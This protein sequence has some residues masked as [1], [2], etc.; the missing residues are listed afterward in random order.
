MKRDY[1]K[2]FYVKTFMLVSLLTGIVFFITNHMDF[3]IAAFEQTKFNLPNLCYAAIRLITCLILPA[4]FVAPSIFLYSRVRIAKVCFY[5]QS[6]LHL[7]TLTW[8][9]YFF[10][11]GYNLTDLFSNEAITFFQQ[12]IS[13]AFI[14][15]QIFWDTYDIIATLFTLILSGIYLA[16]AITF[17]DNRVIVRR[18]CIALLL[19]KALVPLVYNLITKQIIYSSLWVTNNFIELLS[20]TA[21]VAG[22]FFASQ[23]DLTWVTTIWDESRQKNSDDDY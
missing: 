21:F 11:S 16:L 14:S 5:I 1:P 12:N 17:D 20:V 8:I 18:L 10:A 23:D 3:I 13:N 2:Q 19:F 15:A 22:I 4:T 9:I 7:L 6:V